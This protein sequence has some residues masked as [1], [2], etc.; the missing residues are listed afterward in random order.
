MAKLSIKIHLYY[1]Y[2]LVQLSNILKNELNSNNRAT[3]NFNLGAKL[4][5]LFKS[6]PEK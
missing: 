2:V 4:I 3:I 6:V 5:G 1:R